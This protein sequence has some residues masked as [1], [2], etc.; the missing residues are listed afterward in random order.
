M[1]L[2]LIVSGSAWGQ[3]VPGF[4]EG[5]LVDLDTVNRTARINGVLMHIPVGVPISSPTV[6]LNALALTQGVD[7]L[8]LVGSVTLPGRITPGF[9][10]GSCLCSTEVDPLTGIV[11]ATDMVLEP[12][13]NVVLATIT[14]H[15]CVT[16]SCDPDDNLANELRIGGTLLNH[17]ADLR[18]VSHPA[19]NRGFEVNL[20]LG[21]LVGLGASAE[22]YLGIADHLH[23]YDLELMDGALMNSGVTEVSVIR[24]RCVGGDDSAKWDVLGATHDPNT[25]TVT[26]RHGD[27]GNVLG[28]AT[29]VEE[30]TVFGAYLFSAEVTGTCS[31]TV[32]ADFDTATGTGDVRVRGGLA[33]PPV[34]VTTELLARPAGNLEPSTADDVLTTDVNVALTFGG[35]FLLA[36]DTDPEGDPLTIISVASS[37]TAGG[38]IDDNL[39]GT[40][41]YAPALG[42]DG[43]DTFTYTMADGYIPA[44]T[45]SVNLTVETPLID[46]IVMQ[47]ALFDADKNEWRVRGTSSVVGPGNT[48][49]VYLGSVVGG[50]VIGTAEVDTLGDWIFSEQNSLTSPGLETMVSVAS[51]GGGIVEGYPIAFK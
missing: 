11:T 44:V 15:N 45:G 26:L 50:T 1:F 3:T 17:N 24:G 27:N 41:T 34:L 7:P 42:F 12:A 2:F 25:G 29:V 38:T 13:E 37:S 10:G 9:L 47:K 20:T 40:F 43:A 48:V 28:T 39:D 21:N 32:I 19:T 33:L 31:D 30:T 46:T 51:T 18:L 22:G 16:T 23:Y 5:T 8:T 14:T 35:S 49:T 36:N 4:L 6:D